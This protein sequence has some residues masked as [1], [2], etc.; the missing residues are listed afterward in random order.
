[1][2]AVQFKWMS[3]YLGKKVFAYVYECM[4]VY[5]VREKRNNDTHMKKKHTHKVGQF[6]L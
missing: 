2:F 3:F 5:I 6:F 1:M 4:C